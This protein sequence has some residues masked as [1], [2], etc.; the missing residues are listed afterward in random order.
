MWVGCQV[1]P[2]DTFFIK[3]ENDLGEAGTAASEQ[4]YQQTLACSDQRL[5]ENHDENIVKSLY[6]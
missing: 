3:N 5:N 6:C 4:K 2:G 1:L